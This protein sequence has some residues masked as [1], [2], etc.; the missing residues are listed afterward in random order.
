MKIPFCKESRALSSRGMLA[1][2]KCEFLSST[3]ISENIKIKIR[4][5]IILPAVLYGCETWCLAL[6]DEH[7]QRIFKNR[8]LRKIFGPKRD[9][10]TGE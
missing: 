5:T 1:I 8:V 10:V 7:R 4:R 2:I 6:K 3:F 9:E